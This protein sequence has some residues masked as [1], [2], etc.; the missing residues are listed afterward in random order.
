MDGRF[1]IPFQ[2]GMMNST[3]NGAIA[4]TLAVLFAGPASGQSLDSSVTRMRAETLQAAPPA[5]TVDLFAHH[6]DSLIEQGQGQS[7]NPPAKVRQPSA[8]TR[9]IVAVVAGTLIGVGL[10]VFATAK[11]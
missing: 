9:L 2:E 5:P 1:H 7:T 8:R 10:L 6:T 3:A 11:R 4:L